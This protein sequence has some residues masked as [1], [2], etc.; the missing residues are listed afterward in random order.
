MRIPLS[1]FALPLVALVG[2]TYFAGSENQ[3]ADKFV[4]ERDEA[5]EL[6]ADIT[7]NTPKRINILLHERH[8]D[9]KTR[10]RYT[11]LVFK[12]DEEYL[13]KSPKNFA[14]SADV[15]KIL[16]TTLPEYDFGE[17][18]SDKASY[19]HL[20]IGNAEWT[21]SSLHSTHGYFSQWVKQMDVYELLNEDR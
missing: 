20:L 16:Q 14:S 19:S 7:F 5:K 13:P 1:V 17:P 2:F 21:I 10:T 18:I 6:L 9:K 11:T 8:V 3:E 4:S 15:L 12:T